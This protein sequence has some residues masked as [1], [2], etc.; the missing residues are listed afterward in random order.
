MPMHS[1]ALSFGL[2]LCCLMQAEAWDCPPPPA[3]HLLEASGMS[4]T[5]WSYDQA[6]AQV[7]MPTFQA[8]VVAIGKRCFQATCVQSLKPGKLGLQGDVADPG[9]SSLKSVK[10]VSLNL[11]HLMRVEAALRNQTH[12][13]WAQ[14]SAP[15]AEL[16]PYDWHCTRDC[17][18][19]PH[20]PR[21]LGT[22]TPAH[23]APSPAEIA[24]VRHT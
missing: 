13:P 22:D 10:P 7:R 18:R 3:Q 11:Y 17:Y 15:S 1:L 24:H 21:P 12:Q 4:Q 16:Q 9:T 19:I 23:A 2:Q 5:K 20:A 6:V 14:L 8:A